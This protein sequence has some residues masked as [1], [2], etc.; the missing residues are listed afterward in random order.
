ML[1]KLQRNLKEKGIE[2]KITEPL[3]AKVAKL[4]YNPQFGARD[5]RRV[6]QDKI[7]NALATAFLRGTM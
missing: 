7:E 6:I 1:N 2:F 5:M 3:K 4:G